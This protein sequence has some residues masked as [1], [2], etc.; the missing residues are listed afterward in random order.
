MNLTIP[1]HHHPKL[2]SE[3]A[4]SDKF[5]W[6]YLPRQMQEDAD[7]AS[8]ARVPIVLAGLECIGTE[9]TITACPSF[10]LRRPSAQCLHVADVHI[11]CYS[12]PNPGVAQ[13]K[14]QYTRSALTC[15]DAMLVEVYSA[16]RGFQCSSVFLHH[17]SVNF[18]RP[19]HHTEAVY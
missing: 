13:L 5:V 19:C 3:H 14:R 10:Q 2:N 9:Q 1:T 18:S 4:L 17:S 12:G 7:E 6:S 11:V 8:T 15:S 16:L